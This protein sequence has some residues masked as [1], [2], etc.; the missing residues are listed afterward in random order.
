MTLSITI[1]QQIKAYNLAA[2]PTLPEFMETAYKT[3]KSL[4]KN[5]QFR[6]RIEV[7]QGFEFNTASTQIEESNDQQY[8]IASGLYAPSIKIFETSQ[9]SMKCSRGLDSEI[10]K[11]CLLGDDYKKIAMVCEDRNVELHAQYGKH[12]KLRVPKQPTDMIYNPYNCNLLV[13]SQNEDI[14]RL[15]LELGS[16]VESYNIQQETGVNCLCMHDQL[17]LGLVGGNKQLSVIDFR[18]DQVVQQ[19]GVSDI[20]SL[21]TQNLQ[22]ALGT[23]EG[24]IKLFDLRKHIPIHIYQHQYRLP[25][26]KIVMNDDMIVSCDA[27]ILKFWKA[28][29]LF[30]NIEPQNEINSFTWIKN[31]GMFLLAL[32]QPRMGIYFIPQLNS[33][34]KWCPFLDNLTEEMEEEEQQTVYDEYKFLS[35]EELERLEA[36]H[37]LETAMLKP[38]SH[39]YLIHLK[40]YLKLRQQKGLDFDDYKQKRI[41]QNY[42][43]QLEAERVSKGY[44]IPD[45]P[46]I[47]QPIKQIDPRFQKML[48]D[49]DFTVDKKSEAWKR[50]HP[51]EMGIKKQ[52]NKKKR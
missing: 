44:V 3:Q 41:Q 17:Q 16:F 25:I 43:K 45:E 14:T 19:L 7:I 31:S 42:E 38:Y 10:V 48:K 9:L 18:S 20:T 8:I 37:L 35:Y 27:K 46:E 5:E 6:K 26:K 30:T 39:G 2:C 52:I 22:V 24:Q 34:P 32:E 15:N 51:S 36:L 21:A 33:A 11:F 13:S 1:S 40:L 49:N 4:K 28:N 23:K 47:E 12:F 29:R 50:A